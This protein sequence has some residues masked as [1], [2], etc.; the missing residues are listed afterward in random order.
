M[1][2]AA[3]LIRNLKCWFVIVLTLCFFLPAI[4]LGQ[5]GRNFSQSNPWYKQCTKKTTVVNAINACCTKKY[6]TCR[7]FCKGEFK[8]NTRGHLLC[9]QKCD[10]DNEGCWIRRE[11]KPNWMYDF[12]QKKF[13]RKKV[14]RKTWNG[15][16]ATMK[17]NCLKSCQSFPQS[18]RKEI[19][20]RCLNSEKICLNQTPMPKP[21]P[22]PVVTPP[23][24]VPLPSSK[25]A[26]PPSLQP[27]FQKALT[28]LETLV[29]SKGATDPR[30]GRYQCWIGKL[31]NPNVDDRVITWRTIC[32]RKSNAAAPFSTSCPVKSLRDV[33]ED[34][35]K[36][37]VTS[38]DQVEAANKKLGFILH[39][40]SQILRNDELL[41]LPF[42][43]F[44][45]LH[46]Q[47]DKTMDLL[48]KMSTRMFRGGSGMPKYYQHIDTW[49]GQRQ[50]DK[51]SI[52]N[53]R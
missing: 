33:D 4:S 15:C 40:R 41:Q 24:D 1:V 3:G 46:D 48:D 9:E 13:S 17:K 19:C 42:E 50:E 16:C 44:R 30:R 7:R 37:F 21:S 22:G 29:N 39:L 43:S 49:L 25:Q 32:P 27:R 38:P 26:L 36:Q 12:C 53:C 45:A 23:K 8:R 11:A 47:I 52:L 51:Q 31:R 6:Q 14:G 35:L 18:G 28:R 10:R 2:R 5:G 20:A 34:D